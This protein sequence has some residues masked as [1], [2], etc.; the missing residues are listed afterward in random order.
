MPGPD[1]PR[2]PGFA[3]PDDHHPARPGAP[4][5]TRPVQPGEAARPDG[6]AQVGYAP[7]GDAAGYGPRP[8]G[9][10][11]I[12][13]RLRALSARTSLRVK[14]IAGMLVL[15]TAGLTVMS[16][17]S[18]Y[19]LREYLVDRADV[20]LSAAVEQAIGQVVPQ[21]RRPA[22]DIGIRVPSEMYAQ[23]RSADGQ[24][25]DEEAAFGER[26]TPQLPAHLDGRMNEPFTVPGNGGSGASWRVLA[27]SLPGGSI[28]I[29]GLSQD[30]LQRTV[31]QLIA[32]DAIVGVL[33]VGVLAGVGVWV[34]RASMRP[35]AAI[36]QTAGAI[37]AGD[38]SRRVP[39]ADP[40]TEVGR[41]A[42]ALNSMLAQIEAAFRARAESEASARRSEELARRSEE[43]MRRFVADASHELRTPLTAIRGFAEFY[44]QGA[45]RSPDELDRLIG[46]IEDT[47]SRMSLLVEDL[48][49]LARLD[50]QRPIERRPVDLL[51]VAADTVQETRM[52]APDRE[53]EL[54]VSGE[55]AFQVIGDE[56]R[57]RQVLGNLL[58][59]AV[60][61]TPAGTPVEVRL[62]PGTLRD[63]PAAVLEVADEGPGLTREQAERVFERF[64]RVDPA[65]GP[66][67]RSSKQSGTGLGLAIVAALVAAHDGAVEVDS[68]P[69][70][71]AVFRV[72][73]PLAPD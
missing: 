30:E 7:P 59:N 4:A 10:V 44:R 27:E 70:E 34:V 42:S 69:G 67:T 22:A 15:V 35:L 24:I 2:R 46:R 29:V 51:A 60:T 11:R 41:L 39:E 28:L 66:Q 62:R 52:V 50:R 53:I 19:V 54:S 32:I 40:S 56:A 55:V 23:V 63:A 20:Q 57:L 26:G 18:V 3:P 33:V 68:E 36:E 48:L 38:L 72:L 61:H 73:L 47:A 6:V 21:L 45:A 64:Y 25:L 1:Q 16:V 49:L 17:A 71:G 14:L 31:G 37:A 9:A 13:G 5:P 8:G 58:T 12:A 65:R 43:R